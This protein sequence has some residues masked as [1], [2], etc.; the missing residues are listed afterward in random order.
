MVFVF[1]SWLFSANLAGQSGGA[2]RKR[3]IAA[4]L[5]V[6]GYE[7]MRLLGYEVIC[8]SRKQRE[9]LVLESAP[10]SFFATNIVSF[11]KTKYI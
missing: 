8:K 3:G 9:T 10:F 1:L 5:Q 2:G 11:D 7:V 4:L 6:T